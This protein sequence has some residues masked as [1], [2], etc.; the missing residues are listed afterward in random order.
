[1]MQKKVAQII[2]MQAMKLPALPT[3]PP[4][5]SPALPT[6]TPQHPVIL[7]SMALA[8]LLSLQ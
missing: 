8:H 4:P 7:I 2:A 3:S 1:M 5:L 6:P